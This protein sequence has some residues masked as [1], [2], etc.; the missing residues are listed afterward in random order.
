M[1]IKLPTVNQFLC[2]LP[3]E[4]GGLVCGWVTAILSVIGIIVLGINIITSTI[5]Y[6]GYDSFVKDFFRNSYIS[7]LDIL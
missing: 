5:S 6:N 2:C 3:L 7:M 4:T 1:G